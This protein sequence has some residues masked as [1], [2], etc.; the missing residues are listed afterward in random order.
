MLTDSD[1]MFE[2]SPTQHAACQCQMLC[3]SLPTITASAIHR[4]FRD[5]PLA[6]LSVGIECLQSVAVSHP[7]CMEY[8]ACSHAA[9]STSSCHPVAMDVSTPISILLTLT[10]RKYRVDRPAG[11]QLR[12]RLW[13]WKRTIPPGDLAPAGRGSR[14]PGSSCFRTWVFGHAELQVIRP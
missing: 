14:R 13:R 2:L 3:I 6:Q 4:A 1:N 8:A 12:F 10:A 11:S 9:S 5:S 7:T